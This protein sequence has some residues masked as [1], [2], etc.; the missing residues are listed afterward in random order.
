MLNSVEGYIAHKVHGV[1]EGETTFGPGFVIC[2]IL[3][4]AEI[5]DNQRGY[6]VIKHI[7]I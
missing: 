6:L 7:S 2:A 1:Q 4:W 5:Y 3:D